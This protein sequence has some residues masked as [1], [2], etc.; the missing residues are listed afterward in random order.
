[1]DDLSGP[2]YGWWSGAGSDLSELGILAALLT[3]IRHI[4]C[5]VRGCWRL[6]RHATAAG[7][8]VCRHHH[9][10]GAPIA[11]AVKIAHH[12]AQHQP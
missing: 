5:E 9:P 2:F 12:T 7:H 8:K 6:G 10:D 4:N 1:M 3:H 11:K